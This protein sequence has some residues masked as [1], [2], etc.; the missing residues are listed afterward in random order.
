MSVYI[1]R[2]IGREGWAKAM[3]ALKQRPGLMIIVDAHGGAI[4]E[5]PE[6]ATAYTH[7]DRLYHFQILGYFGSNAGRQVMQDKAKSMYDFLVAEGLAD[8]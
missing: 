6:M 3:N 1:R 5:M 4:N 7:R 2:R 8:G